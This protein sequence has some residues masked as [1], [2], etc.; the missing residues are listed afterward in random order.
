MKKGKN[1]GIKGNEITERTRNYE[2][3]GDGNKRNINQ[4]ALESVSIQVFFEAIAPD[5]RKAR[6]Q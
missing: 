6:N 2:G 4:G 1:E 3:S 5:A